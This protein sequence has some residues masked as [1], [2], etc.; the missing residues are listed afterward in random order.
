MVLDRGKGPVNV[1]Q[2][3]IETSNC[4]DKLLPVGVLYFCDVPFELSDF[5]GIACHDGLKVPRS[6]WRWFDIN[7]FLYRLSQNE[8]GLSMINPV[9][10]DL[11]FLINNR[12]CMATF[13]NFKES[14]HGVSVSAVRVYAVPSDIPGARHFSQWRHGRPRSLFV[15]KNSKKSWWRLLCR[16][17][18]SIESWKCEKLIMNEILIISIQMKRNKQ[19]SAQYSSP[20]GQD[21]LNFHVERWIRRKRLVKYTRSSDQATTTTPS[22]T[23]TLMRIYNGIPSPDVSKYT[24][25]KF[26]K[27]DADPRVVSISRILKIHRNTPI[28]GM[29]SVL[30]PFQLKSLVKM[31]EKETVL[32][33]R[34]VPNFIKLES[35]CENKSYYFDISECVFWTKPELY[36]LPCGGI[37]AENMGLGKTIICLG[38]ICLSKYEVSMIP[39]DANLFISSTTKS[40]NLPTLTELCHQKVNQKSL[41][42]K[43]YINDLPQSVVSILQRNPGYFQLQLNQLPGQ[44]RNRVLRRNISDEDSE[45]IT[46]LT[47]L[48][49]NTTLIL[50][51]DNLFHQWNNEIKKHIGHGFLQILFI[52]G[53]FTSPIYSEDSLYTNSLPEDATELT[54]YDLVI[55][56]HSLLNVKGNQNTPTSILLKRIYWKRL[57]IDEGH[58]T[59]SRNSKVSTLCREIHSERRWAVTGTPTSGLTRLEMEEDD[60]MEVNKDDVDKTKY[61][62]KTSINEKDDLLKLGALVGSFLKIEPYHTQPKMWT[63]LMSKPLLEGRYGSIRSLKRLLENIVVRHVLSDVEQD[64][65]LPSLHHRPVFLTPSYHNK[66]AVNMFTAVLAVNAVSSER[67]DIDYMFHPSNRQQLRRLITNLQRSTFHW[68]GFKQE[69]VETLITVCRNSMKKRN[70]NKSDINL[71]KDSMHA[72]QAALANPRWR[73]IALLHEMNYYVAG[74]PG[75][76]T[77]AFSMGIYE[78]ENEE[79]DISVLGA[80]HISAVQEFFYK[81]RFMDMNDEEKLRSK[82]E[83]ASKSFWKGYWGQTQKRNIERFNKQDENQ[84]VR[85]GVTNDQIVGVL[86]SPK[87]LKGYVPKRKRRRS[88]DGGD[89]TTKLEAVEWANR[90]TPTFGGIKGATI[91]GTAS[92][93]LSYISSRLLEHQYAGVKSIVFFEFEDSAYYLTESLDVLGVNYILYATFIRPGQRATNLSDFSDYS[94]GGITLIM[95]L[96]LASHGLNIIAA[97]HVYFLNPVWSRSVE[98][99]AIKR[100]HRIGQT[101]E[102]YVETL[103][104]EGTLE[105]EIYKRRNTMDVDDDELSNDSPTTGKTKKY[106]IDDT[107]MQQFILRHKF[108]DIHQDERE[109]APFVAPAIDLR[110]FHGYDDTDEAS[111]LDHSDSIYQ[112]NLRAWTVHVFSNA[113]LAKLNN[114]K[115]QKVRKAFSE[116]DYVKKLVDPIEQIK[117]EFEETKVPTRKRVR[118]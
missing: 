86:Q 52:S 87:E 68:T 92:A 85:S 7:F 74:L 11:Q 16:M 22:I 21:V 14:K 55:I 111:L 26:D 83:P 114:A 38:L 28:P 49:C 77:G 69:D 110:T 15:E 44:T 9:L 78:K 39:E 17:D 60:A 18:F 35:P 8:S 116:Q 75:S 72:A 5:G 118:F 50:V 91:L 54:K 51:P 62:V 112:E 64:L 10:E 80:P 105:E 6:N 24:Q 63:S 115:N 34:V 53:Q 113:N 70:H 25:E 42:W 31:Y 48:L 41:P 33:T 98:A 84:G 61:T 95:D 37:L 81:N 47:L 66:L 73:T 71:L 27:K 45:G 20:I 19:F 13:K 103:I 29:S 46:R 67:T 57:I 23:D 43:R 106:V 117:E 30:Y 94:S 58:S 40:F 101:Q 109:Y 36:K 56:S 12:F 1:V 107:G 93:K 96:R 2:T 82:L 108:L 97:T 65:K 90:N 59:T 79:E 88:S 32:E 104:L 100:A 89:L 99:Q 3:V 76:F 102:V 4:I